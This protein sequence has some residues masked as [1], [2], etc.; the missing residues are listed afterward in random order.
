MYAKTATTDVYG[1]YMEVHLFW[2]AGSL[3]IIIIINSVLNQGW[4]FD[5]R[6]LLHY[7]LLPCYSKAPS[8]RYK[9]LLLHELCLYD[10]YLY[11]M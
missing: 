9:T 11:V 7:T 2:C 10:M 4:V 5:K 8:K 1:T 3:I 6:T